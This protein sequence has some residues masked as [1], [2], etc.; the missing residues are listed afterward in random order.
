MKRFRFRMQGLEKVRQAR[1][2]CARLALARSEKTRRAEEERI[3]KL[4]QGVQET[5]AAATREGVL[6]MTELLAEQRYIAELR[7]QREDALQRLEAWIAT[8]EQDR[9]RLL[10][11]SKEQKALERLRERRYLE[12]VQEVLREESQVSDEAAAVSDW[13]Q[14]KEA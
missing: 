11:A 4:E 8:V 6:D 7:R 13:R 1:V 9:Q 2:D 10:Q 14:R 3:M 5:T 12:F